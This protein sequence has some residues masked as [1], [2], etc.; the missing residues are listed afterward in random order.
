VFSY[1]YRAP[2]SR[3]A[4]SRVQENR[5][6]EDLKRGFLEIGKLKDIKINFIKFLLHIIN[7][8]CKNYGLY[9]SI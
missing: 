3:L 9:K 4:N 2:I 7:I 5:W 6:T 1:N 8:L